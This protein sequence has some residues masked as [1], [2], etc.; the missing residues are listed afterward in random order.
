MNFYD[1]VKKFL[2]K[3]L[4]VTYVNNGKFYLNIKIPVKFNARIIYKYFYASHDIVKNKIVFDN[5]MGKGFG[6][7]SKYVVQKLI[8]M[9]PNKYDIVWVVSKKDNKPEEY[10]EGVRTVTY[11]S[12]QSKMEYATSKIWVSNYHKI[13]YLKKGMYKKKGQYFIQMWHGSLGI[14]RIEND[15]PILTNDNSW[16]NLAKESS[17]MVDYWI[18]NSK[19]ETAIYKQ[20]FWNVDDVLEYGHPRN[21]IIFEDNEN[22]KNKVMQYFNIAEK[23]ILFYAPTFREDYRLDCYKIDFEKLIHTLSN[24][25]GGE[26]V[27]IVR[28]HPRVRKYSKE[29]LGDCENVLDGTYYSDIQE[30]ITVADIMI[31]DYSSCIFDFLLTKRPGFIF[32]TD[33]NEFNN[34][35]G[36]Y[37][38]LESTPFSIAKNN[39]EL[40]NNIVNFD[41]EIYQENLQNF[42][43]EKGCIEDG[44]ASERV[45]KLIDSLI[46]S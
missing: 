10:P 42:L 19:F 28:L 3:F 23:K 39:V 36:F 4:F 14:K 45:A 40:Q 15:V 16:L 13:S 6:C 24:K 43:K 25:F 37:Y 38:P 2:K 46:N 41:N 5:Y 29:V 27:V 1:I 18:S 32:A 11:G 34:E 31:T 30:L 17:N 26:W 44:H 35:R 21:D 8:E 22:I 12:V 20:A 9:Y 7:N 33:I